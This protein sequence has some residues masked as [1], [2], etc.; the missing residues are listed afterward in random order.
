[1]QCDRYIARQLHRDAAAAYLS[2]Q[3]AAARSPD[4]T[5]ATGVVAAAAHDLSTAHST[6]HPTGSAACNICSRRTQRRQVRPH[7]R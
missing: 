7:H 4:A 6:T 5:S 1:V 3:A 2:Q